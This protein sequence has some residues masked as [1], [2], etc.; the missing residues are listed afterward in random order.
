[1]PGTPGPE[2][3]HEKSI[4]RRLR[5]RMPGHLNPMRGMAPG[6]GVVAAWLEVRQVLAHQDIRMGHEELKVAPQRG[7]GDAQVQLAAAS[8]RHTA[9]VRKLHLQGLA[10]QRW[11]AVLRC[12]ESKAHLL[13]RD[14][15]GRRNQDQ[16]CLVGLR[17]EGI[18]CCQQA[19]PGEGL[20]GPLQLSLAM[21]GPPGHVAGKCHR[22]RNPWVL[23]VK[24]A[25]CQ[26]PVKRIGLGCRQ[27][28]RRV[29]CIGPR[30]ALKA[31]A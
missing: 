20:W 15:K 29:V 5:K 10:C 26:Q 19:C 27:C 25:A 17:F 23:K 9:K 11:Q 18:A 31:W 12:W 16:P 4:F 28:K 30:P 3:V 14:R 21:P 8:L 24:P 2:R 6:A 22:R 7:L 1:M 13:R